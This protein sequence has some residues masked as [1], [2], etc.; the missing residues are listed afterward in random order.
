MELGLKMGIELNAKLKYNFKN[1][2]NYYLLK[3]YLNNLFL[4]INLIPQPKHRRQSQQQP[5][6]DPV[7]AAE[8]RIRKFSGR[9]TA[10]RLL[11]EFAKREIVAELLLAAG[12]PAAGGGEETLTIVGGI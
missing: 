4:F 8:D 2:L 11:E 10:Q 3:K 9:L 1:I 5:I 6:T 7:V 12:E